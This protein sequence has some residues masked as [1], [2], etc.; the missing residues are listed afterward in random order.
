[1][2]A[3]IPN[4]TIATTTDGM[5][6]LEQQNGLDEPDRI[7]IHPLHLRYMAEQIGLAP[8]SDSTAARTIATL[9]RRLLLLR[10]RIK[11]LDGR[12]WAV[13]VYPPGAANDD[14]DLWFSDATVI[15]ADEF[16]ADFADEKTQR[17][18][19]ENPRDCETP[20][21]AAQRQGHPRKV[22][23]T[24]PKTGSLNTRENGCIESPQERGPSLF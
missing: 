6:E 13:P 3:D 20:C 14:P 23:E 4:L 9:Q 17:E 19:S 15:L 11:E 5:I 22:D 2:N 21:N 24:T 18:P 1:M 12:L 16:C 8:T 10:D 7:E